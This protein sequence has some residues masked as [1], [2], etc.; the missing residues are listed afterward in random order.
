VRHNSSSGHAYTIPLNATVAY[1]F[2][3]TIVFRNIGSGAVTITRTSGV[4]LWQ[5]GN[6][7]S[8]DFALAQWGLATM[9]LESTDVW[10]ISG[11]GLS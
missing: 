10:V 1:P 11:T 2:G 5:A 9:T 8:K 7:T 6:G 3:T 4:T